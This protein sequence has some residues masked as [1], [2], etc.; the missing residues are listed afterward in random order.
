M[1]TNIYPSPP[2]NQDP[3][4]AAH[5]FALVRARVD[6]VTTAAGDGFVV[7]RYDVRQVMDRLAQRYPIPT[8]AVCLAAGV[9]TGA[10]LRAAWRR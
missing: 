3:S 7:A 5:A 9:L 2:V 1:Q 6:A 4:R 8:V 10:L